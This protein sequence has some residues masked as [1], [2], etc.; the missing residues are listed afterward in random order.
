[1]FVLVAYIA[2]CCLAA[3]VASG[4]G[5]CGVCLFFFSLLLSPLLGLVVACCLGRKVD[6]RYVWQTAMDNRPRDFHHPSPPKSYNHKPQ[7]PYKRLY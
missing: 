3:A 2:F 6:S 7:P 5:R 4:K 1:M